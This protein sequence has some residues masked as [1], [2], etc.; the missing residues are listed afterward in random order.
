M[1]NQQAKRDD[2]RIAALLVHDSTGAETRQ[3]RA[4]AEFPN[5]LPTVGV[6]GM[7]NVTDLTAG[8]L[9]ADLVPSTDVSAYAAISLQIMAIGF[10][11]TFTFQGSNDN[12]DWINVYMH[13]NSSAANN[14]TT[15]GG[16]ANRMYLS[17]VFYKYF[18]VRATAWTSGTATGSMT[19]FS[20]GGRAV[21]Y[22]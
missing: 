22:S 4:T 15:F 13:E 3:V 14:G 17:D 12:T 1:S 18:R 9:N 7:L 11:G 16:G 21:R 6:G 2:N 19:L 20:N 10:T 5:S 8:S